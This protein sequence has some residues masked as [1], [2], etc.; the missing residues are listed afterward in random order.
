[1]TNESNTNNNSK[2][3]WFIVIVAAVIA[4]AALVFIFLGKN[5]TPEAPPPPAPPVPPEVVVPTAAPGVPL[6]TANTAINVR[7]GPGMNYPIYGVAP[8]GA[9]AQVLGKSE[10]GGWWN[11]AVS[12][13]NI[14]V[15]NAW[16]SADYVTA[17]G[18]E[19]VPVVPTPP[20]P[21]DVGFP[22]PGADAPTV[23]AIDVINVRSGP[24]SEY[25]SYGKA[26]IGAVAPV[27]GIN[28]DG[29]WY[30][31]QVAP[32][33][34]PDNAG[35]VKADYVT[36]DNPSNVEIPVITDPE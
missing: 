29:T 4:A 35:W 9:Q 13:E 33:I 28:A 11:I 16:V 1:M 12:T 34:S 32:E 31:V 30:V 25:P 10:D 24:G 20:L 22:P 5:S 23:T 18:T 21:P 3:I 7:S 17:Q 6:V 26:P 27:V 8:Q 36:L 15:G 19:N 14:A 2:I